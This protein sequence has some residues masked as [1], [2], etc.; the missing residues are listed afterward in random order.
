M[1][2][3]GLRLGIMPS[4]CTD[5]ISRASDVVIR[6]DILVSALIRPRK[7]WPICPIQ[8]IPWLDIVYLICIRSEGRSL[9]TGIR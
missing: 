9:R 6:L 8:Q 5:V 7:G 3:S 2:G 1:D 4:A